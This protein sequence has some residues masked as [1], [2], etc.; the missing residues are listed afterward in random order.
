MSKLTQNFESDGVHLTKESSLS[1]VNGLLF[2]SD[3]LFTAEIIDIEEGTSKKPERLRGKEL[4]SKFEKSVRKMNTRIEEV[5]KDMFNRR[6][7]DSL[8]MARIREDVDA[9]SNSSKEDKIVISGMTSKIPRPSGREDIRKWLKDLVSEVVE[10]IEQGSSK[11]I[12][13]I[14]QGRS[15][16]RNIP[17]AE[18]R[19]SSKEV[20]KKLRKTL[21]KKKGWARLWKSIHLKLCDISYKSQDRNHEGHGKK[22]Y[23][24]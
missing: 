4:E 20:A 11:E 24:R 3:A 5:N 22:I 15:N 23:Y 9:I 17:L 7:H 21:A 10:K 6:F 18:V 2:N 14:S 1:Y 19:L 13:F 8:V 12:I 16:N